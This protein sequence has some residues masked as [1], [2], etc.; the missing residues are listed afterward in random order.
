MAVGDLKAEGI[1]GEIM[2]LRRDEL[3]RNY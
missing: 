3:V 2:T 1:S